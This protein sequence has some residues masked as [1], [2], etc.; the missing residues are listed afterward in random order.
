MGLTKPFATLCNRVAK[1]WQS[2]IHALKN[3]FCC[4]S[5]LII[6]HVFLRNFGLKVFLPFS[7]C[8]LSFFLLSLRLLLSFYNFIPLW[9]S[10]SNY[11]YL[12]PYC[13]PSTQLWTPMD[14]TI[15]LTLTEKN[16]QTQNLPFTFTAHISY[17]NSYLC[18]LPSQITY[19]KT[20]FPPL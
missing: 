20:Y 19:Y 18:L 17:L 11:A 6:W 12:C 9:W 7:S 16:V 14:N 4:F 10:T 5:H 15:E 8:F 3:N 2:W 13:F 1:C